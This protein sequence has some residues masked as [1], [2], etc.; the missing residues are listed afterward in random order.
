MED[1]RRAYDAVMPINRQ[2]CILQCTA[3]YPAEA[4]DLHL[5]VITTLREAFPDATVGLSDHYNGISMAVVAYVLGARVIEKHFTLNHTWK[6]TD[7]A[8][9]LEPLGFG[10]MVRDLRRARM[11]LGDGVKRVLPNE[12][13]PLVKMGKSLV[14]ARSLSAGHVLRREDVAIKSPAGGLPPY[15]LELLVGKRL[16]LAVEE[17]HAFQAADVAT[18]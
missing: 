7:H 1:I 3:A 9:S 15:E 16:V 8:F 13:A 6:G 12:T 17:D 14:A 4:E 11:A 10:K 2:L 5:R 18:A